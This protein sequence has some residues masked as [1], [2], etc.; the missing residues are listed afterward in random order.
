MKKIFITCVLL[1][2]LFQIKAQEIFGKASFTVPA[3]WQMTKTTKTVT[4]EKSL[5]KGIVCRIIISAAEKGAVTTDAEYLSYRALYGGT[6]ITYQN[7]KGAVTKY[8]ANGLISFFQ[9]ALP[10]NNWLLYKVIFT[11]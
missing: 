2:S 6:G 8:E 5:K 1:C 7:Q 11:R 3:G 9:K 10:R 4:L